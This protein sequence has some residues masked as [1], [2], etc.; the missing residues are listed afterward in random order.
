MQNYN[1]L[2]LQLFKVC[3]TK[4]ICESLT[5]RSRIKTFAIRNL[6]RQHTEDNNL[7]SVR[8]VNIDYRKQKI[9]LLT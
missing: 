7:P 6:K 2:R 3:K 9:L 8:I 5:I 1:Y 4:V